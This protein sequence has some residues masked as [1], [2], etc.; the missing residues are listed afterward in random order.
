MKKKI[1]LL[2]LLVTTLSLGLVLMS[3]RQPQADA[4]AE[5]A[6][7]EAAS[8]DLPKE[9]EYITDLKAMPDGTIRALAGSSTAQDVICYT[10]K[11]QGKTWDETAKYAYK[12]PITIN[13]SDYV[14]GYGY[15]AEDGTIGIYIG[16]TPN[17]SKADVE[18]DCSNLKTNN[19]NFIIQPNGTVV[20][21]DHKTVRDRSCYK[22]H[23]SV[24][25][26]YLE[27]IQGNLYQV[28]KNS[29]NWNGKVLTYDDVDLLNGKLVTGENS[30]YAVDAKKLAA[31]DS[32]NAESSTEAVLERFQKHIDP[33]AFE[34]EY[35]TATAEDLSTFYYGD[36]QGLWKITD[37]GETCLISGK[38]IRSMTGKG[39]LRNL[40][41]QE[42]GT[43]ILAISTMDGQSSLVQY[44]PVQ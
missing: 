38:D 2:V 3:F 29:G 1:T 20:S 24:S 12:L 22:M 13:Q 5:T 6:S 32:E 40:T 18:K 37:R 42:D 10:S 33:E 28:D 36:K 30:V 27:D 17:T 34:R 23:F 25:S 31:V 21:I 39:D 35:V 14:E 44:A 43:M 11:D 8:F 41:V 16:I 15:L 19:Y 4:D 9:A 7:Y 26:C